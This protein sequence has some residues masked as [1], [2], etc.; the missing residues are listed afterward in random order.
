MATSASRLKK[1][2]FDK[3]V[4]TAGL[5]HNRDG[6]ASA[7]QPQLLEL[8][9]QGDIWRGSQ[10]RTTHMAL[11]S[12]Y[13]SFDQVLHLG[14]WPK[15]RLIEILTEQHAIGEIQLIL[16]AIAKQMAQGGWL[17][18]IEPPFIPYAP[19]W[20]K[21]GVPVERVM[22]IQS[23][24]KGDELWA[25][26][27]V[28]ANA[29]VACCLFWPVKDYLSHKHL[30]RLQLA[31]QKGSALNFI[32]RSSEMAEQSSAASLRLLINKPIAVNRLSQASCHAR[33]R[34]IELSIL[35]QPSGWSGQALQLEIPLDGQPLDH[36]ISNLYKTRVR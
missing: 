30:K 2:L 23:C 7:A 33:H 3:S 24:N 6:S 16:P 14:G 8:L 1:P 11:S 22:V 10:P 27:Q 19:A 34:K 5:L 35:K 18:L 21:A 25:C 28:M 15:N 32:F 26:E 29:S 20:L 4:S 12:G 31:T 9:D 36:P 13:P 17:F